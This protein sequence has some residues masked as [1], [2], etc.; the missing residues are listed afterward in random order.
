[1]NMRQ[2]SV[3]F[4]LFRAGL[5]ALS[6][7][8][9]S[10]MAANL[11][12]TDRQAG[13]RGDTLS[14]IS[15]EAQPI[16]RQ[17]KP[18]P[19][20]NQVQMM[21]QVN[22]YLG[23]A[24]S[25]LVNVDLAGAVPGQSFTVH[26][27]DPVQPMTLDLTPYHIRTD[28]Y[29]LLGIGADGVMQEFEPGPERTVRGRVREIPG[30]HVAGSLMADGLYVSISI[31]DGENLWVEAVGQRLG[32]GDAS[33][34]AVY[35]NCDTLEHGMSCGLDAPAIQIEEENVPQ[36]AVAGTAGS[37]T[38]IAELA[39]DCDFE[40]FQAH[41]SS[42]PLAQDRVELVMNTVNTQYEAEVGITHMITTTLVRFA[43]PD[44]YSS[45]NN[46]DLLCQFVNEW[47][48]LH[49]GI[50]RDVAQLWTGREITGN[51][52]GQAA[53]IG[54]ICDDP[55]G[56]TTFPCQCGQFG[57]D[58]SYCF[59]QSDFNGNFSCATDLSAHE[60][61]HLWNGSHCSCPSNTMN[62]SITCAN[63]FSA[64][65][66]AS[67]TGYRNTRQCLDCVGPLTFSFPN[68]QPDS[69]SPNGGTT[70]RVVVSQSG[71]APMPGTGML[72]YST[73]G[74]FTSVAMSVVSDNVYDAVFP[75]VPCGSTLEYYVSAETTGGATETSPIS[76]PALTYITTSGLSFTS[77]FNDDFE[78]NQGWTTFS[79]AGVTAGGW[80]RGVPAGGGDRGDP[81]TDADGSGQCYL[82][83]NADGD[84]DVD[85]GTV[86][87]QSPIMD[88]TGG[89][90]A[91]IS[92]SRWFHN[93]FGGEPFTETFTVQVSDNGGSTWS[94][95][96]VVGPAGPE[97]S[98]GWFDKQFDIT[99]AGIAITNQFRIR[100]ITQD[101]APG[102][103]VEAAVDAVRLSI[104]ECEAGETC[105]GDIVGDDFNP[106]GDGTV[107]GPDL[108]FLLVEWGPNPG[109]L[110][111][112]VDGDTFLPPPDGVVDGGDLAYLLGA[113][114][115]CP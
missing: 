46:T 74:S 35:Q 112:L 40:F 66:I 96:E 58:G 39:N 62:P 33:I 10:A 76:A 70:M 114:G 94:T 84:S 24:E 56:C 103:V 32:L 16:A 37:I 26:I 20:Q 77:A 109:S 69:I 11:N 45:L 72:H 57:T 105:L 23:I 4:P 68:G 49:S 28:N 91:I 79:G 15:R 36:G 14:S 17:G 102:S 75:A 51:V 18:T 85:G 88:A 95:L 48:N 50:Q 6:V 101:P 92:Y 34:H 82:T 3:R 44:P 59:V 41:G 78:T 63:T 111:D 64:N 90:Q 2:S 25:R 38:C 60:L 65:T 93:S 5:L 13:S 115:A 7:V 47:V 97:V 80:D 29:R 21:Q 27:A 67:I 55:P 108:A 61:G 53:N 73:G 30:A 22:G 42:V 52:I 83:D 9:L 19:G 113:W 98:G 31:P 100:F 43:E 99:S 54:N 81:P 8:S 71:Q 1:M 87:L 12:P 89:G 86:T 110:A 106:P 104:V 107:G